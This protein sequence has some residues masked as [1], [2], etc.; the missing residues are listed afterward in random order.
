VGIGACRVT[1]SLVCSDSGLG[2]RC[3]LTAP[4]PPGIE[5][6]DGIDNDCD[7][8]VDEPKSAPGTSPTYVQES[9]V[10]IGNYWIYP[11]EAS[12]PDA[13]AS[14]QGNETLRD[15]SRPGVLPWKTLT[16]AEARAA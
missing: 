15:C 8:S 9:L 3:S 4:G 7:G 10:Q 14:V 13:T 5:V 12:R 16:Y 6:C 1:G 11:Y 2:K